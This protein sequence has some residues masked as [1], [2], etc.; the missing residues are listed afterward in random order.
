[1]RLREERDDLVGFAERIGP[2]DER[3]GLDKSHESLEEVPQFV[4]NASTP[5]ESAASVSGLK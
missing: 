3:F 5:I 4:I 2:E 1:M